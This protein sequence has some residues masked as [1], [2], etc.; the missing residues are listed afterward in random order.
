MLNK[1][2]WIEI[3]VFWNRKEDMP[4]YHISWFTIFWFYHHV[5]FWHVFA[6]FWHRLHWLKTPG[7]MPSTGVYWFVRRDKN[8]KCMPVQKMIVKYWVNDRAI[9]GRQHVNFSTLQPF[10]LTTLVTIA[11]LKILSA[12]N[13]LPKHEY[14]CDLFSFEAFP[15]TLS[16]V[17]V[18]YFYVARIK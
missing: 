16:K 17:Q 9:G 7:L 13:K 11:A 1:V 10:F 5:W 18:A 3:L 4:L 2:T 15:Y 14:M 8:L 6:E 12:I